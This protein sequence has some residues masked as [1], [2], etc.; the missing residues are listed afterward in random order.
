MMELAIVTGLGV[1]TAL[2][3]IQGTRFLQGAGLALLGGALILA[4]IVRIG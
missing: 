4:I 3:I 1:A 2:C